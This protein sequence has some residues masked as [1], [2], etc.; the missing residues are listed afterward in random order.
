MKGCWEYSEEL[1]EQDEVRTDKKK[2]NDE[3]LRSGIDDRNVFMVV[4]DHIRPIVGLT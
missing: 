1:L 3:E 2:Q 4:L